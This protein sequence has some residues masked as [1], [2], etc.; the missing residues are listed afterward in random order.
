MREKNVYNSNFKFFK[1]K[2]IKALFLNFRILKFNKF[3]RDDNV[4]ILYIYKNNE[5]K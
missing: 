4:K 1:N 3:N 5:N 2:N